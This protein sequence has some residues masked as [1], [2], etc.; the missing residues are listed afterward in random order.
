MAVGDVFEARRKELG[1]PEPNSLYAKRAALKLGHG[2]DV[3]SVN[4]PFQHNLERF[5]ITLRT[6][7]SFG[8]YHDEKDRSSAQEI[9]A[10][11]DARM[12]SSVLDMVELLRNLA[13]DLEE[14]ARQ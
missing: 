9:C 3:R 10:M 14:K 1:L 5:Y 11:L 8:I 6:T 4:D 12:K 7:A 13:D 2:I